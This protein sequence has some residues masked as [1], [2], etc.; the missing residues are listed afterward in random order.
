MEGTCFDFLYFRHCGTLDSRTAERKLTHKL[1]SGKTCLGKFQRIAERLVVDHG[2][3]ARLALYKTRKLR[4]AQ[5]RTR[6][7]K[8]DLRS[9]RDVGH[10]GIF[11]RAGS[12]HRHGECVTAYCIHVFNLES[13]RRLVVGVGINLHDMIGAVFAEHFAVKLRGQL[14][15]IARFI[16]FG[17]QRHH[18]SHCRG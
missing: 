16:R 18:E 10:V 6:S 15:H 13:S 2:D 14:D 4:A 9:D 3:A 1:R 17:R 5:K 12:D 7:D 11:E 8:I